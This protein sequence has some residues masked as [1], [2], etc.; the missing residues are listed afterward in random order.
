MT[1]GNPAL[2]IHDKITRGESISAE[3]RLLLDQWYAQ[4]DA[5]ENAGLDQIRTPKDL[6]ALRARVDATVAQVRNVTQ[7]IQIL[8]AET[9]LVR[10]DVQVLQRQLAQK[11]AKMSRI[12]P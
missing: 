7:R 5:E 12:S 6:P 1:S 2:P 9:E 8:A 11:T 10:R 3:E 4:L